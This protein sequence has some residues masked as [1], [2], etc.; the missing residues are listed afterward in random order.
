[1][2][3]AVGASVLVWGA[4]VEQI[5]ISASL[6]RAADL[7]WSQGTANTQPG[8]K[9]AINGRDAFTFHAAH[10]L[11]STADTTA[12]N[13]LEGDPPF[14]L[15]CVNQLTALD[16]SG[17]ILSAANS[18]SASIPAMYFG[19]TTTSTGKYQYVKSS[20]AAVTRIFDGQSTQSG[21]R[22]VEVYSADGL[23][24]SF[25]VDGGTAI[26]VTLA[27]AGAMTHNQVALGARPDSVPDAFLSGQLG[28]VIVFS[29]SLAAAERSYIR[30]GCGQAYAIAVA[31]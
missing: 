24:I 14:T 18:G 4:S 1:V 13:A 31:A 7:G 5:R 11:I 23:T 19:Q 8:L 6:N 9:A 16:A 25:R 3:P 12:I 21:P 17:L 22:V 15:F 2:D 26:D 29:R 28:N 27:A 20:D 30:V 10:I